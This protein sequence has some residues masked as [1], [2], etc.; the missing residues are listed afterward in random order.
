MLERSLKEKQIFVQQ[1]AAWLNDDA[2]Q[3]CW[4]DRAGLVFY[5]R[6]IGQLE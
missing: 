4:M 5:L 6:Q 2:D 3:F 1:I